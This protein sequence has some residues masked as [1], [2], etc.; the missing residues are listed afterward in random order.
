MFTKHSSPPPQSFRKER[1][2]GMECANNEVYACFRSYAYMGV[3]HNE[4]TPKMVGFPFS[5]PNSPHLGY[6]PKNSHRPRFTR[7]SHPFRGSASQ[8]VTISKSSSFPFGVSLNYP[9]LAPK[10]E[11]ATNKANF[12][13]CENG[14][15]NDAENRRP[16]ACVSEPLP[17]MDEGETRWVLESVFMLDVGMTVS[18]L[19]SAPLLK[20]QLLVV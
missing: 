17:R 16:S 2:R 8:K 4:G 19:L 1:R 10:K 15:V 13:L 9:H 7:K 20:V 14:A 12:P 3:S 11:Q 5:V 18:R 6:P